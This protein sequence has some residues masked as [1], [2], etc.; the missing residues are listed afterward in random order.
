MN[1]LGFILI[2]AGVC[3]CFVVRIAL[4]TGEPLIPIGMGLLTTMGGDLYFR[5]SEGVEELLDDEYGGHLYHLPL[6]LLAIAGMLVAVAFRFNW[7]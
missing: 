6:W 1:G 7:I 3:V 2:L 4:K 5:L